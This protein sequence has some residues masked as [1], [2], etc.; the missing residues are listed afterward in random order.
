MRIFNKTL[1]ALSAV[2]LMSSFAFAQTVAIKGGKVMTMSKKGTFKDGVIIIKDGKITALGKGIKIPKGAKI[3]DAKGK[4][5]VPGFMQ[6]VSTLGQAGIPSLSSARDS[7]A[8]GSGMTAS[9]TVKYALNPYSNIVADNRRNGLTRAVSAPSLSGGLF[10]GTSAVI[11]L[12]GQRDLRIKDGPMFAS[13]RAGGNGNV[14]WAKIRIIMDQ[15][16]HYQKNR[17]RYMKGQGRRDYMLSSADMDALI[18]VA[19]GVKKIAITLSGRNDILSAIDFKKEYGIDLIIIGAEEAWMVADELA[20]SKIPV[21]IDA[22]ANLPSGHDALGS[23]LKNAAYLEGAGV[24]F[25]LTAT[26]VGST[27]TAYLVTQF[28]G[29]AVAHGLSYQGALKA[30]TVNPAKIF[31]ISKTYGS[32]K[33]GMDA[34]VVI[35]DGDPLEVT[36]NTE[37]VFVR[38]IEYELKS[39]RSM[40]RDRYLDLKGENKKPFARR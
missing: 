37:H 20:K 32:L 17:A 26:G 3:I 27:H 16:K 2:S 7:S 1:I 30:I 39:R 10:S 18:P 13:L 11:T 15:V 9:F 38:G 34:D 33:V 6:S 29:N 36:S 12:D 5:I 21:V 25:S 31:G 23:T 28:A 22:M 40:L 4:V 24:L 14:S 35:W 8:R 19:L